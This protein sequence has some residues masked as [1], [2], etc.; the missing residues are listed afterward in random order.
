LINSLRQELQD[1]E[2]VIQSIQMEKMQLVKEIEKSQKQADI[3]LLGLQQELSVHKKEAQEAMK[4]S[5][6]YQM[7]LAI[8]KKSH[9][10]ALKTMDDLANELKNGRGALTETSQLNKEYQSLLANEKRVRFV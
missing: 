3:N 5:T 4:K 6:E 10:N 7:E 1:K 8:L 9:E 2:H